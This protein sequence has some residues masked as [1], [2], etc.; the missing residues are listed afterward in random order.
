M[1]EDKSRE[2]DRMSLAFECD[3]CGKFCKGT[4]ESR[5]CFEVAW[6][7]DSHS[8]QCQVEFKVTE[9]YKLS[10]NL[11]QNPTLCQQCF[12]EV[13]ELALVGVKS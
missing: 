10:G 5:R 4:G 11:C 6:K 9:F 12:V 3:R 13:M 1:T 7:P 2:E 8:Y